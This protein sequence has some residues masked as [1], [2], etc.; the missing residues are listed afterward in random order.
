[1]EKPFLG[2]A[3][4]YHCHS[5]LCADKNDRIKTG[6]A[7]VLPTAT[8]VKNPKPYLSLKSHETQIFRALGASKFSLLMEKI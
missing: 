4:E 7:S 8:R 3:P 6:V 1:M 5:Y 2:S